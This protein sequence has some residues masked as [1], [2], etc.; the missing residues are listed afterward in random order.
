MLTPASPEFSRSNAKK[1]RS[2]FGGACLNTASG[3]GV[4]LCASTP[5]EKIWRFPHTT[6]CDWFSTFSHSQMLAVVYCMVP[7]AR[8]V[9][10]PCGF[11]TAGSSEWPAGSALPVSVFT[12]EGLLFP[13]FPRLRGHTVSFPCIRSVYLFVFSVV[14]LIIVRPTR[15]V[16]SEPHLI[17]I[18]TKG[19]NTQ[20]RRDG[21]VQWGNG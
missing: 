13:P 4:P 3:K 16:N 21:N 15:E 19:K 20:I 14:N 12:T 2:E 5:A 11:V 6:V 7:R 9:G 18:P 10:E 17:I 8:S 1:G